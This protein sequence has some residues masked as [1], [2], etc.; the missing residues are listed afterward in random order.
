[1]D[2]FIYVEI[3][4]EH[5][6][7]KEVPWRLNPSKTARGEIMFGCSPGKDHRRLQKVVGNRRRSMGSFGELIPS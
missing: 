5:D 7:L 1:M 3:Y 2:L 6:F 4:P